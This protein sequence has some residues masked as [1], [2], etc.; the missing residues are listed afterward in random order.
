MLTNFHTAQTWD[1]AKDEKSLRMNSD[2]VSHLQLLDLTAARQLG[3][4]H[5]ARAT[6]LTADHVARRAAG[7]HH[8]IF[9][10]LYEYY[11]IRPAHL[12]RW[13][14]GIG[15]AI[16]L[17]PQLPQ[18]DWRYYQVIDVHGRTIGAEDPSNLGVTEGT[19]DPSA[20]TASSDIN[21]ASATT[22]V[23]AEADN[24]RQSPAYVTVDVAEF[25]AHKAKTL[26]Y[27]TQLLNRTEA[28]PTHFDCF[29][30]HEWAMV[31][32]TNEPR[33]ALPLRLGAA[34]TN[35]VV[36]SHNIRCTHFDA[37]RFFT[38]PARPLNL[39]VLSRDDQPS[40][41]QRACL[42]AGMDLYKWA[43]KLVPIIPSDLWLDTFELARDIRVLDMEASPYDCRALGFGVVAIETPEGKAE[44]VARQRDFADR[45]SHLRAR[46]LD[47][48]EPLLSSYGS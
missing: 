24:C 25:M 12:K 33:H 26:A 21:A 31:Y 4:A 27:I 35:E 15:V 32:Q 47:I 23:H 3:E 28:N 11:P 14:P 46:M 43:S 22:V 1:T 9:D 30:L 17:D 38:P 39:T 37:Y 2:L 45:A 19:P 36:E 20:T 44:Y 5:E 10:F 16:P 6:V 40:N 42:H 13:H 7:E 41:E 8:P 18:S 34:A 29:G 48:I